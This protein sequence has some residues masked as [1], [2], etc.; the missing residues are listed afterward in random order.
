M[1]S[2]RFKTPPLLLVLAVTALSVAA[3]G[4]GS[5]GPSVPATVT[6][7]DVPVSATQQSTSALAFV[8]SVVAKGEANQDDPLV[9]GGA[10]LATSESDEPEI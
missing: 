7:T 3:C 8:R 4:G 2:L 9:V 10:V 6:G 5:D 1:K